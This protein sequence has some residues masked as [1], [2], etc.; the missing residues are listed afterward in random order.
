MKEA[1]VN[2]KVPDIEKE[3]ALHS[4]ILT[5]KNHMVRSLVGYSP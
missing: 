2:S 5:W 4:N 1:L 3:M